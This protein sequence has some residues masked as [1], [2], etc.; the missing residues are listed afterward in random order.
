VK[1]AILHHEADEELLDSVDYYEV[2]Q[3]GAG[4]RLM[5]AVRTAVAKIE[6]HPD[7][8]ARYNK[9]SNR[10][11]RVK[12]FPYIIYY[13]EFPDHIWVG[14]IAHERRRPGYW[15]RRKPE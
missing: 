2:R 1:P 14:A 7:V 8:G 15:K 5:E 13:T 9:T 11:Y 12:K 3:R 10:F 6:K 4:I